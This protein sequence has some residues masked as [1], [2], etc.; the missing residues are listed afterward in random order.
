MENPIVPGL[1]IYPLQI[2][3]NT[4]C[5]HTQTP[6]WLDYPKKKQKKP[7]CDAL[8]KANFHTS[9]SCSKK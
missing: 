1:Q 3:K 7:A 5:N 8:T 6:D 2:T 9:I 4:V